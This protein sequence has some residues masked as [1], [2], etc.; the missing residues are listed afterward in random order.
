MCHSQTISRLIHSL[1]D[2]ITVSVLAEDPFLALLFF[3]AFPFALLVSFA[4]VDGPS[5]SA[6]LGFVREDDGG[7]GLAFLAIF[8]GKLDDAGDDGKLVMS[9]TMIQKTI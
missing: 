1:P 3:S 5:L 9:R 4:C 2:L 6:F 8:E 7:H